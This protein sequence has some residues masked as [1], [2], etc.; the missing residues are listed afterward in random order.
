MCPIVCVC[1]CVCVCVWVECSDTGNVKRKLSQ[2]SGVI[3]EQTANLENACA[4][5]SLESSREVEL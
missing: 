2:A 4:L 3:T 5:E 1:V